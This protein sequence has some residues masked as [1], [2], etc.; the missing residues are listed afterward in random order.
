MKDI[1]DRAMAFLDA[2]IAEREREREAERMQAEA[3]LA[4]ER[5]RLEHQAQVQHMR[6]EAAQRLTRRTR[7][8]A[9]LWAWIALI[10]IGTGIYGWYSAHQAEVEA[11]VARVAEKKAADAKVLADDQRRAAILASAAALAAKKNAQAKTI[12][13]LQQRKEALRQTKVAET[14]RVKAQTFGN[15]AVREKS[16]AIAAGQRAVV[17]KTIAVQQGTIARQ[18]THMAEKQR[19]AVF[20]Q[21]GR[22]A[23]LSGE[24]DNAA[25]L[26]AAAYTQ[27][28]NNPALA[29]ILRQA[30]DKLKI[31]AGSF[32]AQDGAISALS[33]NPA[34]PRQF[35]T[36]SSDGS[37]K[38]WDSSGNALHRFDDQN[39]II[40]AIAF[41]PSGRHLV[42]AGADGS[43]K[44]RDLS[45]IT[46]RTARPPIEL[47]G[48]T[49]RINSVV[50]NHDG[51]RVLTAGSDGKVR[52]W[53]T[54]SGDMLGDF[55]GGAVAVNDARY[56]SDDK[57]IVT[58][59]SDG[60]VRV[61][62]ART[63]SVVQTLPVAQNSS[64]LHVAISPDGQRIAAGTVDGTVLIYDLAARK[65]LGLRHDD[66]VTVNALSFDGTGTRLLT[67]SDSGTARVV[68]VASGAATVLLP[69]SGSDSSTSM[70]V[71]A[72]QTALYS[73]S[74]NS[75]ATTYA[76][77]MVRL[78]TPDGAPV[79]GFQG[80][81]GTVLAAAFNAGGDLLATGGGDGRVSLWRPPSALI[82]AD[83]AQRG[84]ID[85]I[86]VDPTG[87]RML[88]ASHDGT[89]TIWQIG[90]A[91]TR[92]RTLAHSPGSAWVTAA[93]FNAAGT[94]IM[95]VGGA[96][97]KVWSRDG[98]LIETVAPSA[99]TKRFS[100][101]Q[102]VGEKLLVGERTYAQGDQV[103][104]DHWRLLSP[105]GKTTLVTEPGSE[106]GIRKLEVG[107]GYVLT[108]TSQGW[109]S[110]DGI[111]GKLKTWD[112][113]Y[114]TDGAVSNAHAYFA[115]GYA[116][117][118]VHLYRPGKNG[119]SYIFS[120][121]RGWVS[122]LAFSSDD[123]WLASAGA[124]DLYGKVWDVAHQRLHAT[125]KGHT[126]EITSIAFSPGDGAF[127]LTTSADGT[128]KL[129][130]RD[131]GSLLASVTAPGSPIR[132]ARFAPGGGAVILGAANGSVYLW[133][134]GGKPPAVDATARAVLAAGTRSN[135]ST[136]LLLTQALS[137]LKTASRG[138]R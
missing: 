78:W 29:L 89:V 14:E 16:V 83:A 105:D 132:T 81:R 106:N 87:R 43:A 98:T 91:L 90:D 100:D 28:P 111:D 107:R 116:N 33:F 103:V 59:S 23:L 3:A 112:A 52:V 7:L 61:L 94:K 21:S 67:G 25:V 46:L 4:A 56:A 68:V 64:V 86:T 96:A 34:N 51:T 66:R 6:A 69:A 124:D 127:I 74:G 44:I 129:W 73:P 72:V 85:A 121:G 131:T 135:N 30:L 39:E 54:A 118:E 108:L 53:A 19:S 122:A 80:H 18:Q 126:G 137:T 13:A 40:T 97:V 38:L 20:M 31:R 133:N 15:E 24:D 45:G 8:A 11:N 110:Y 50:F 1:F 119:T 57:L 70:N 123:A 101:G 10:A 125:L 37:A 138:N 136:D 93:S 62:D 84:V 42:T 35:A 130:D 65:Q 76:D 9:V 109:A 114:V 49:R 88:T 102:F 99:P 58:G 82:A 41:D 2:G 128:A 22:E 77:G 117:G 71:G 5:E 17:Q 60:A 12:E 92:V 95:T 104:R 26:L 115:L 47:K 36:A 134:V 27:D 32:Q 79:A 48:H 75:I 120:G 55:D 63:G 113:Q